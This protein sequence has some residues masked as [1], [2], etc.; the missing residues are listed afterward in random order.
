M[1]DKEAYEW[2][3]YKV[4]AEVGGPEELESF[5]MYEKMQIEEKGEERFR[6][7]GESAKTN[8]LLSSHL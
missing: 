2:L 8:P 6:L 7:M 4:A 5:K 3:K 1:Q